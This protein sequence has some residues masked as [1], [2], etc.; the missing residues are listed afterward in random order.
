MFLLLVRVAI[1]PLIVVIATLI[2]RRY[3]ND[4]GGLVIGLPLASLPLLWL[5]AL[6]HGS[7]FA[8]SMSGAILVGASAQVVV[9]WMY[10]LLAPRISPLLALA[11]AVCSF[12]ITIGAVL[13]R[14]EDCPPAGARLFY[15]PG[16]GAAAT[17]GRKSGRVPKKSLMSFA[18]KS[19][20][21]S[22]G[23]TKSRSTVLSTLA[24]ER[25]RIPI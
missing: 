7:S 21:D 12:V 14:G 17:Y 19:P 6:Q 2:Q 10:A 4:I 16:A 24:V 9:I 15:R 8:S 25:W 20:S 13:P 23:S 3:G 1:A 18:S 5:V 22:G 11:G